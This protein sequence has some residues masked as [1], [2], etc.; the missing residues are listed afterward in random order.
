MD[1]DEPFTIDQLPLN[2]RTIFAYFRGRYHLY[3]NEM[4]IARQQ[5]RKA[6]SLSQSKEEDSMLDDD[7][8]RQKILVFLIPAEM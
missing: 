2:L 7:V 6:L 5:L 1:G 8:N 4:D 3:N